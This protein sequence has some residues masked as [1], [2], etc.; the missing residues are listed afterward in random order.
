M[1]SLDLLQGV[2]GT[3]AVTMAKTKD[4]DILFIGVDSWY[5]LLSPYRG[6]Y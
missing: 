2:K 3:L 6:K 4:V 5:I 1:S